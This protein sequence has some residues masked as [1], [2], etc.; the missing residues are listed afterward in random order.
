MK[1]LT[2]WGNFA[3]AGCFDGQVHVWDLASGSVA[4][5]LPDISNRR[6]TVIS[7]AADATGGRLITALDSGAVC[8]WGM[9]T[10]TLD[11]TL[12]AA[13]DAGGA[14]VCRVGVGGG[15]LFGGLA[16]SVKRGD[17][18]F[19]GAPAVLVWDLDTL[20]LETELRMPEGLPAGQRVQVENMAICDSSEV[21]AVVGSELLVWGWKPT[22]TVVQASVTTHDQPGPPMVS[23][24]QASVTTHNKPGS[25]K[26]SFLRWLPVLVGLGLGWRLMASRLPPWKGHTLSC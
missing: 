20:E 23:V 9:R 6:S 17:G 3:A 18:S 12:T 8:V 19:G 21:W 11:R 13:A 15:W 10:W 4:A 25:P 2:V 26:V 7:M 22:L 16:S 24:V 1:C 5:V 14:A